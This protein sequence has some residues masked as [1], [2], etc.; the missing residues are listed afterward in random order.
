M[1]LFCESFFIK[2]CNKLGVISYKKNYLFYYI[3]Y[4][5]PSHH[6]LYITGVGKKLNLGNLGVFKS[7]TNY[8]SV[9]KTNKNLKKFFFKKKNFLHSYV[10]T[11]FLKFFEY[12]LKKKVFMSF[13]K[14]NFLLFKFKK[15]KLMIFL[16]KKLGKNL[17]F[18][19]DKSFLQ[20]MV[21]ILWLTFFFK[22]STFFTNWFCQKFQNLSLRDHKKF[23]RVLK[24]VLLRY[25]NFFFKNTNVLGFFFDVRGKL[26][27]S[28]NA[29]KRHLSIFSGLYSST[30]K[31]LKI[32]FLQSN[33]K[34]TTGLL[35]VTFCLFF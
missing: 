8:N 19:K 20:S 21:K 4:K 10:Y 25:Y 12:F 29:K 13:K 15:N 3:Q 30:N 28:G 22:D 34:T 23:L 6:T 14:V 9:F 1:P 11:F 27:V 18:I 33:V 35:G 16:K 17:F 24:L 31:S 26:G 5:K 7:N 32:N 2:K